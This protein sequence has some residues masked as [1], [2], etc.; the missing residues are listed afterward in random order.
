[1]NYCQ[2]ELDLIRDEGVR[3]RVYK[4]TAGHLTI[5]VGH[6][7]TERELLQGL[8]EISLEQ[9]GY[10]L[11][12]DIGIAMNGCASIFGRDR[13]D[14]FTEAR[15]RALVNMCFQLGTD[16][17][18]NFKRMVAAILRGDWGTAYIEALDSKWAR[19]D[20]PARAKRVALALRS[21]TDERDMRDQ[22]KAER[23]HRDH[24]ADA[25]EPGCA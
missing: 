22:G 24:H 12:M 23:G 18:A 14:S 7:L 10:L 16:G 19:S 6:K 3:L 25:S 21:D 20:S 2:T 11:H 1:M 13:F 15:Q 4:C 9:A 17:L 5:G 8:S